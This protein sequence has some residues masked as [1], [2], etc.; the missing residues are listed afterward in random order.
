M[1]LCGGALRSLRGIS[2]LGPCDDWYCRPHRY[3]I[4]YKLESCNDHISAESHSGLLSKS[5]SCI[6]Q[7]FVGGVGY[8]LLSFSDLTYKMFTSWEPLQYAHLTGSDPGGWIGW[9][10]TP[11]HRFFYTQH[12]IYSIGDVHHY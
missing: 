7:S 3:L 2:H 11:L 8:L 1:I 10:A 12:N 6:E 4:L 9:L 5:F